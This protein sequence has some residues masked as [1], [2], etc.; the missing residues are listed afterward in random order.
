MPPID[1]MRITPWYRAVELFGPTSGDRWRHYIAWSGLTWLEEIISVSGP[2]CP[3]VIRSLTDED[4]GHN[5]H[6]DFL[7]DF[8][9]DLDYLLR[10]VA[11]LGQVG[12]LAAVQNP[13]GECADAFSDPRFHFVGY[14]LVD[15][16]LGPSALTNCGGFP[17]AFRN[18][19]LSKVG[20]LASWSRAREVQASLRAHH[21][22]E[23][24][25]DVDVW[26]VWRM[27]GTT[28]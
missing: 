27:Q 21:P 10:R 6:R 16:Q 7:L 18:E 5:V 15:K 13:D 1:T 25:A 9:V 23:F 3:N 22:S 26:A 17:L 2:V 14:D 4:W 28:R 8:F 20:L 24:H 12:I 19:E 11:G